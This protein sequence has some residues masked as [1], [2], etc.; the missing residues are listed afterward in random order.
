MKD[1]DKDL[2]HFVCNRT[3]KPIE[4]GKYNTY[5]F[6]TILCMYI[7]NRFISN[8]IELNVMDILMAFMTKSNTKV[9]IVQNHELK[10]SITSQQSY[11]KD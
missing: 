6:V 1:A 7:A 2:S 8:A 10:A 11:V 5:G 9:E 3:V 4:Y